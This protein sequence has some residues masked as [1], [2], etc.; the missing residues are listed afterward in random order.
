MA[1][2]ELKKRIG[3]NIR[4]LRNER[5]LTQAGLAELVDREAST[6]A[7]IEAGNQLIGV[8]LL[9][10]LSSVFSVNVDELLQKEG[11]TLHLSN[12]RSMLDN[13]SE[14]ALSHIEPVIRVLLSEYGDPKP[15]GQQ[16]EKPEPVQEG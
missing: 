10:K 6:I 1:N 9:L 12:I 15:L 16:A 14:I 7:N 8:E 5:K 2:H 11:T 4:R 13:Q 3:E